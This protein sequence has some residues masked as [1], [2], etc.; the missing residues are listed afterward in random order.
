MQGQRQMM[1]RAMMMIW[2][3]KGRKRNNVKKM[4]R[5]MWTE[6]VR[7]EDDGLM[8]GVCEKKGSVLLLDSRL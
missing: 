8:R 1:A 6:M 2:S 7:C 3:P 4:H 5:R